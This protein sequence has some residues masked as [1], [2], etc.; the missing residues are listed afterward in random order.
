MS[1]EHYFS[2]DPAV[3]HERHEVVFEALDQE[4]RLAS[5]SG[6]FSWSGL[7]RGTAVLLAEAPPPGPDT[8]GALLD[9]GCGYGPISIVLA[10]AAPRATVYAIDVNQRALDLVR[11][12]AGGRRIVAALPDEVPETV[13]F[14]QIW[15]NPPI[16]IGKAELHALLLRWLPR[17]APDGVAW[18][19]VAKNL[20]GDSLQ[21]W[22]GEQGFTAER[23]ATDKGFRVLRVGKP[24]S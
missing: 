9:L 22:L 4:F 1:G 20:G 15:S 23:H 11:E 7:D 14:T 3:A 16:R 24:L 21:R 18:L 19:V 17:L 6:V 12:N 10:T 2:A 5:A 8:E 13:S